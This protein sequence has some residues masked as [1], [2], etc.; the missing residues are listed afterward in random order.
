MLPHVDTILVHQDT[1]FVKV[2]V[3]VYKNSVYMWLCTQFAAE[4]AADA[5]DHESQRWCGRTSI[6]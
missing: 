1:H 2:C 6:K 4:R 5:D 3:L